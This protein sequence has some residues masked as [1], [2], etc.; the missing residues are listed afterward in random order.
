MEIAIVDDLQRDTERL[1]ALIDTYSA[2]RQVAI[3]VH[4][5]SSGEA[6]LSSPLLHSFDAVV[7]DIYM[8]GMNGVETAKKLKTAAPDCR[9]VFATTS[10]EYAVDGFDLGA[11]HYL[12]KPVDGKQLATAIDRILEK[13]PVQDKYI[14]VKS[15]R[16]FK[17]IPLCEI[18]Y[19]DYYAHAVQ[20]HTAHDIV[21]SYVKF[22]D[23]EK[24]LLDNRNFIWCYRNIVVNMDRIVHIENRE[25]LLDCGTSLPLNK[26]KAKEIRAAYADYI[27]NQMGKG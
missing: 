20:I 21:K 5:F 17:K 19:V 16:V 15:G 10:A 27:F 8:T 25:V 12:L 2:D 9:I 6:F 23:L 13:L 18:H 24:E 1:L 14:Q 7:I 11:V 4:A 26:Q 22:A 3:T